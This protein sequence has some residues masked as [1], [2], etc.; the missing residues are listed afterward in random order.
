MTTWIYISLTTKG[1]WWSS[2]IIYS[3][4]YR[5]NFFLFH[6]VLLLLFNQGTSTTYANHTFHHKIDHMWHWF[7]QIM[8]NDLGKR[9][10]LYQFK[11]YYYLVFVF[12]EFTWQWKTRRSWKEKTRELTGTNQICR[13]SK[14]KAW[15]SLLFFGIGWQY[16]TQT[17]TM[18]VGSVKLLC[19]PRVLDH[20]IRPKAA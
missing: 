8:S 10:S 9:Y 11:L 12:T 17:R 18:A 19:H 15:K 20:S 13:N 2:S 16:E 14:R 7:H 3:Q 6:S 1:N 4:N 5:V